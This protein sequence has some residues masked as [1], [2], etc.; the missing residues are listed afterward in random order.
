MLHRE[1][2]IRQIKHFPKYVKQPL[3]SILLSTVFRICCLPNI[4]IRTKVSRKHNRTKRESKCQ[5]RQ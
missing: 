2:P 3:P 1:L 4:G 5:T